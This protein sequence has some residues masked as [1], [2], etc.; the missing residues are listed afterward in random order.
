MTLPTRTSTTRFATAVQALTWKS[1]LTGRPFRPLAIALLLAIALS[2]AAPPRAE[3][4]TLLSADFNTDNGGFSYV[5]DT[6]LGTNQPT[7]ASGTR[8]ASGGFGGSGGVQVALGGINGNSITGMSGGW[9][10]NLNFATAE[11]G[12]SV[13][14][15]YRLDQSAFYEFDEYSRVMMALDST[16]YGR[17]SKA[18]VDHIG[19]DGSSTQGN[20]NNFLP[21]TDW[22][23]H[24]IYL[25]DVPAGAHTLTIGGYNNKKNA[26]D[27][28][29]TMVIDDVVM[30]NGNTAPEATQAQLL[31]DRLDLDQYKTFLQ[32]LASYGDRCRMSSCPGSPANSFFNAQAWVDDELT[33]MGYTP[34]Y[35]NSSWSG[36]SVSNLYVTKIG[37]VNPNQM[38]IVGAHLD[39]RG[40]GGGAD[41]DG[42]GIALLMEI[43]R[44]LSAPDVQT[45]KSVRLVFW[46]KE[47]VGLY[48][49]NAYVTDRRNLQGIEEP[50]GSGLYPEPTWLGM[51][52]HDMII[53]D[54]GAGTAGSSQSTYADLDVEWRAG[55]AKETD[56]RALALAWR[57]LNGTYSAQYPATAYNYSTNTD[58]TPFQ[59]YVASI[60]VRENRRSLTSGS[61]AE[62]INPRYHQTTDLYANYSAED[63]ALGFNAIQGTLATVATLAN[64]QI[65]PLSDPPTANPQSVTTDEDTAKPITL[66]G[67]DPEN[68]PLTFSI[69]TGP[70]HG[71]LSG[72]APNVTYTPA[73]NYNGADSFTFRVH[74]GGSY[75]PPATVSITVNAVADAPVA[76]PQ[77]VTTTQD[78]AKPIT[79]TGSDGDND[80][81]SFAVA[82]Q[83]AHGSLSG[84]AP[85]VTYT[86]TT[87]YT[88]ADSFTFTVNDGTSTSPAATVSITVNLPGPVTVFSDNFESSQGWTV[89]PNNSDTATLGLWERGDPETTNSSGVKQQGTTVSGSN[90]LVT[91][92][93]AGGSA[94]AFDIDGGVT[95]IR[96]PNIALPAGQQLTLSFSYYLAHG[97]NSSTADYLRVKVVGNTTQTLLEELGAANDDDAAWI[98]F[99]GNLD[100]F[101]GQTVYLLIEAADASGASL[102]EAAVDDVAIVAQ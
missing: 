10:Y 7:Y 22:Q 60:S 56:S 76:N 34:Q 93:L 38:Y 4:A 99:S 24:E 101:A 30:T 13:S 26:S 11:T 68:D 17:G 66:T 95:S 14:F 97:T 47:E 25:G 73:V 86:P 94:G 53:Y 87:G 83:P 21:T 3:A 44:V 75:S 35:H 16:T 48:G 67:S 74:D 61:N 18:Y 19:G 5:D 27:E 78:T 28:T 69:V 33:A 31:V 91:G 41:D 102:V 42:S 88:G 39:G 92:R 55:T 77:S 52:Q 79:L 59:P 54:H 82:Q 12:V 70:A 40:G 43:A 98:T 63:F 72:S 64:G 50:A 29:T 49:S 6:F 65:V 1:F 23:Q 15:R 20:S 100:S 80:P 32:T 71:S 51:L 46:D 96:S 81:L 8:L 85:N 37:T 45:D 58:D 84:T 36:S 2:P 62:W 90:D 89:N 9:R 57:F